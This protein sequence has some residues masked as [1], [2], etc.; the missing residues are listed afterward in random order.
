MGETPCFSV[1]FYF[2]N[3]RNHIMSNIV[4][5]GGKFYDF[6]TKNQSFLLTAHELKTL[7]IKNFYFM[8]IKL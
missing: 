8:F 4:Q 3:E 6:G 5:L 2:F 1:F 7:G